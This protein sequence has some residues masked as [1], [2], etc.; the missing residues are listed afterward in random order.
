DLL[1]ADSGRLSLSFREGEEGTF[2]AVIVPLPCG[3]GALI[4]LSFGIGV[5]DAVRDYSL[6][7]SDF[8]T[9]DLAVE[10]LYLVE[11]KSAALAASRKLNLRLQ[12][13]RAAAEEQAYTDTLTGLKNRRAMDQVLRRLA[14]NAVPF[15]LVHLD[16][17]FFKS[18]N[19]SYGH[20][21]GDEVLQAVARILISE[22]RNTD[23]VARVGGD[24]FVLIFQELVDTDRLRAISERI[25]AQLEQPVPFGAASCRIS[26]SIGIVT[27]AMHERAEADSLLRQ[28]DAAL[29]ASKH[30][31]RGRVTVYSAALAEGE[32]SGP[33]GG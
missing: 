25:I 10:M 15:G 2:K 21:A 5:V 29:Y 22:T 19:D 8:A 27:S 6:T 18:V 17:D 31:G 16:L 33:A 23:T 12:G 3:A 28:A 30:A 24:E 1:G 7:L 14:A 13:A 20:A 9:T 32:R 4:N 26:G 11:A